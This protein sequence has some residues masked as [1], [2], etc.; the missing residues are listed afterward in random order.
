MRQ[1]TGLALV[2]DVDI[3]VDYTYRLDLKHPVSGEHPHIEEDLRHAIGFA[4]G[5]IANPKWSPQQ[6]ASVLARYDQQGV[7]A[8][9][10]QMDNTCMLGDIETSPEG[11]SV[12]SGI[13]HILDAARHHGE[14]SDPE[15]EVGDLQ[16]ALRQAWNLM[17]A[18]QRL[19]LMQ[20][21]EMRSRVIDEMV[22][23]DPEATYDRLVDSLAVETEDDP[24][25]A[26]QI[27]AALYEAVAAAAPDE[28][29]EPDAEPYAYREAME[30]AERFLSIGPNGRAEKT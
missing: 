13:D 8:L 4:L 12:R 3:G 22:G 1:G 25:E 29:D 24:D 16:D 18:A 17:T 5:R 19:A 10:R 9:A 2:P 6:H 26:R 23:P 15:H 20:D 21:D 27:V 11:S 7:V 28:G 14:V 30:A